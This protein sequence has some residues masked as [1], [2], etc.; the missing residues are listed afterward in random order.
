MFTEYTPHVCGT[1]L[2]VG[3]AGQLQLRLICVSKTLPGHSRI[4]LLL[5]RLWLICATRQSLVV[6]QMMRPSKPKLFILW[7]FTENVC[8]P[9]L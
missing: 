5:H 2:D 8:Q 9:Q 7:P 1:I 4:C 6:T 3:A